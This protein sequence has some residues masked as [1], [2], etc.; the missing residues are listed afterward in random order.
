M[1]NDTAVMLGKLGEIVATPIELLPPDFHFKPAVPEV[2]L[3]ARYDRPAPQKFWNKFPKDTNFHKASPYVIDTKV[4]SKW[5][6]KLN[7]SSMMEVLLE[8][9]VHDLE[10]WYWTW[11]EKCVWSY[12]LM[13]SR[14]WTRCAKSVGLLYF[15]KMEF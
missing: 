10:F 4:L 14:F 15:D 2:L 7:P 8:E 3:L 6:A 5:V 11:E 1:E 9:V 13:E 12:V